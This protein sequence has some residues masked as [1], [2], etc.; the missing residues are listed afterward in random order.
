MKDYTILGIPTTIGFLADVLA[1]PEF[2][3]GRTH[4]HF[5]EQHFSGWKQGNSSGGSLDIALIAAALADS[6]GGV[7]GTRKQMLK[8]PTPW[9]TTG[10]WT[11]GGT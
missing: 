7:A 8:K 2:V 4:T 6:Q 9:Q 3:A 10:K 11:I 1:H 5:I